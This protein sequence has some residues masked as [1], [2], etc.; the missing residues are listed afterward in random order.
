MLCPDEMFDFIPVYIPSM[1][2]RGHKTH[3]IGQQVVVRI[4][5]T[6]WLRLEVTQVSTLH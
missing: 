3:R 4:S 5:P 2:R 6:N 1:D